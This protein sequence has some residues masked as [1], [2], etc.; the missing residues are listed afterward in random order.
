MIDLC[1]DLLAFANLSKA[2]G[3]LLHFNF[4]ATYDLT[5]LCVNIN[6]S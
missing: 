5:V 4:T 2:T 1:D 6:F 3:M